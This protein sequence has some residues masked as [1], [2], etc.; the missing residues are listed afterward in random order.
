MQKIILTLLAIASLNTVFAQSF[1]DQDE[2]RT[3]FG[4]INL[5]TNF[6]QVDGDG[7]FGY[8]KVNFRGGA[9]VYLRM[10]PNLW[11]SMGLLYTQKGSVEKT[12]T[13][14]SLGPAVFEYRM[15]LQ[16]AEMP[17]QFHYFYGPKWVF[18]GGIAYARLI[19]SKEEAISINPIKIDPELY[20]FKRDEW[21]WMLGI[22]YRFYK[23]WIIQGHYQYSL[24]NIREGDQLPPQFSIGPEF[25]NMITLQVVILMG[26][27]INKQY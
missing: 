21:S 19:N 11:A 27:G 16:Y 15:H 17:V 3:F 20:P 1:I 26:T 25:N 7:Y 22:G 23:N 2:T 8:H 24:T 18:D 6:S 13:E 4:G 5:G 9:Q 12:I 14:T 10:V